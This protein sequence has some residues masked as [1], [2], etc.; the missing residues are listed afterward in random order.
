MD[1]EAVTGANDLR[2]RIGEKA[3]GV[4]VRLT[5]LRNGNEENLTATLGAPQ[6]ES[7]EATEGGERKSGFL[8]GLVVVP[9][10]QSGPEYGKVK[11]VY[12]ENID[13][14]GAAAIAGLRKGDVIT[15]VDRVPV[16]SVRQ[17]DRAVLARPSGEPI[18]LEVRRGGV[19]MFIAVSAMRR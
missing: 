15:S 4:A 17:F 18:L 13:P 16:A 3:P 14:D 12:V 11:G 8:S 19:F 6:A 1:G 10:P 7:A 5:L 9:L 2:I